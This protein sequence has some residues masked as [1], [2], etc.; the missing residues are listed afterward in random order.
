MHV[1]MLDYKRPATGSQIRTSRGVAE[2]CVYIACLNEVISE[3]RQCLS[4]VWGVEGEVAVSAEVAVLVEAVMLEGEV[5]V[6]VVAEGEVV[7]MVVEVVVVEGL[8]EAVIG[9]PSSRRSDLI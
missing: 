1:I 2:V 7:V 4:S 6:M 9:I 3:A 5:V 8:V